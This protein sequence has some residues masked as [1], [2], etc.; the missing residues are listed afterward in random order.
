MK[1]TQREYMDEPAPY[2]L[3]VHGSVSERWVDQYWEMDSFVVE[4]TGELTTTELVGEVTDQAA[5]L[6]L[7]TMLYDLGHAIIIIERMTSYNR[8][9]MKT[10]GLSA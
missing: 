6:G 4:R 2:R 9:E 3:R 1:Y 5:L 10:E 7:V 8:E